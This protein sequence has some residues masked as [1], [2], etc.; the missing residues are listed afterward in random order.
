MASLKYAAVKEGSGPQITDEMRALRASP[1][2]ERRTAYEEGRIA[3]QQDWYAKQAAFNDER[4]G[5]WKRAI[6]AL[7]A[8]GVITAFGIAANV[9]TFDALGVV[10]AAVAACSAW[11]QVKQ[12]ESLARAYFIASGEL[13]AIRGLIVHSYTEADWSDFVDQS[14]EAISREHT[15]WRASRGVTIPTGL[16][17]SP[18][19]GRSA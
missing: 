2:P 18:R 12:H 10:A 3:D 17:R 8:A 15:L 7:E 5:K 13:S 19:G 16:S 9:I 1:L 6:V 11:L 14:E 4:A